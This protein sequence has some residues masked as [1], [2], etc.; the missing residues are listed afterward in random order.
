LRRRALRQS[1]EL[2]KAELQFRLRYRHQHLHN[3]KIG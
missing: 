3:R 2:V 1:S